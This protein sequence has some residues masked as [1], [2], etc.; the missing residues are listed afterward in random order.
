MFLGYNLFGHVFSSFLEHFSP[1]YLK[2]PLKKKVITAS[3]LN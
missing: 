1:K 2:S 3:L